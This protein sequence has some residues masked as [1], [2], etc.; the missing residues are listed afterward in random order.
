MFP[1]KIIAFIMAFSV[2][3]KH[4]N[5]ICV[6][7]CSNCLWNYCIEYNT[8]TLHKE[9][10]VSAKPIAPLL[11]EVYKHYN[12]WIDGNL[13]PIAYIYHFVAHLLIIIISSILLYIIYKLPIITPKYE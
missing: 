6:S 2:F 12:Q 4:Y 5:D 11:N 9:E 1:S 10:A 3:W 8:T 13:P 7:H